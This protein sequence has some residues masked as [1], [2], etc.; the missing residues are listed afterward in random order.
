MFLFGLSVARQDNRAPIGGW[1]MDVDHLN[2]F[3]QTHQPP[4]PGAP[5]GH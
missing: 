2:G 3:E 4:R 1:Q 5:A